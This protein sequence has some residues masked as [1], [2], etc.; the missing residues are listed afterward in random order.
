MELSYDSYISPVGNIHIVADEAG[1]RE[2]S[3]A[4]AKS[5]EKNKVYA[6]MQKGSRICSE[7]AK[8]LQEYFTGKRR[9]FDLPLT[10]EG[11][12]FC[13]K[14]WKELLKIPFGETR[15]YSDIA[16]AVGS[17][18]GFRAIGQANRRNPIAIVVPCHRV[19]GKNGSMTG[20][21]GNKINIKQMLLQLESNPPHYP[22][23]PN[24]S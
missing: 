9:E 3:I 1:I 20:Y 24:S 6:Q 21:M 15:S 12:D 11:T 7:A 8:Q 22:A 19:L 2:I 18:K 5:E 17:P 16:S 4:S 13:K 14:V 10:L 23:M